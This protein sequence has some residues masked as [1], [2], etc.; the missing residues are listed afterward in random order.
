MDRFFEFSPKL[1]SFPA[2]KAAALCAAILFSKLGLIG[3]FFFNSD[4]YFSIVLSVAI[5]VFV[6]FFFLFQYSQRR[7]GILLLLLWFVYALPF[8]HL[9]PYLWFDFSN[10]EPLKLWG[11]RVV[12]YMLNE[13][14]IRL[15]AM[16]GA[17]GAIGMAFGSA[18][19][20]RPIRLDSGLSADGS[21]RHFS[22]MK[23]Q[24]WL[25]WLVI[26][27]SLSWLAAPSQT[28]FTS[29]YAQ[30]ESAL[31]SIGF[32][33]AWM[34]SYV[35]LTFT[36]CD[37]LL[38]RRPFRRRF[39]W[40]VI[41]GAISFIAIYLQ[42][43]RGDRAVVT[44][45]FALA[46]LYF[47]WAAGFTEKKKLRIPWFKAS[48]WGGSLVFVSMIL[49]VIRH[50]LV[51]INNP[52][53]VA[54][55]FSNLAASGSVGYE[56]LLHG[57][58]S[59]VLLTPLSVAGDHVNGLLAYKGGKDYLNLLLSVPP[60][61]VA[62]AVNYV[63]PID[64]GK[65]PAWEMR[66]GLGGTHGS[67]VPFMNFRMIGVFLVPAI[68][69]YV[70]A[71]YEKFATRQVSAVNLTLLAT[72]AFTSAHWLWYGEKYIINAL[73]LWVIFSF[74]YRVSIALFKRKSLPPLSA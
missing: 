58:W 44:W 72:I 62:D 37:A 73:V 16:I 17:M 12:P 68:W 24:I 39:K 48:L 63:R 5:F 43:L 54:D 61:F 1:R 3:V 14:I 45:I 49:G 9:V 65:G 67:V 10:D 57:T 55:L 7:I 53:G 42:F 8:I 30:S 19:S 34:I 59:A 74:F 22:T 21:V 41:I 31:N 6:S 46:L 70:M 18:L 13:K 60:G 40:W 52:M 4:I 29:A 27:V 64:S 51:G 35:V 33:S 28:L 38:E 25:F 66:Y 32:D 15:T 36:F 69:T 50:S 71:K 20:L 2:Y 56:N 26:G 11:L 23:M 47:Y